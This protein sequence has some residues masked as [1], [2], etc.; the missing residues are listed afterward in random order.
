[1]RALKAMQ[2]KPPIKVI[3]VLAILAVAAALFVTAGHSQQ[4]SRTT[5]AADGTPLVTI[6]ELMEQTITPATNT[7]WNAWDPPA[8]DEWAA[9]EEAAITMLVSV[10]AT[11]LGGTGPQ[12]NE[13]VA[14][15]AW[16]AFNQ[17][18]LNA[19]TTMLNAIRERDHDTLLDAGD[20]LYQSC[21]SCHQAFNPG[22]VNQP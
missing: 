5:V 3:T 12:D 7:L 4:G 6:R 22:V 21:E 11:A 17:I 14:Q 10:Q 19:T 2:A 16:R 15:P 18:M 20:L 13:W 1:M 9:L 8:D